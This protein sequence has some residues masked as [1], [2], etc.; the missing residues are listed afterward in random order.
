M[1]LEQLERK[2]HQSVRRDDL[3][4]DY[5][6]YINEALDEVQRRWDWADTEQATELTLLSGESEVRLPDDF[7][8]LLSRHTS[9]IM[10][11][12]T[13]TTSGVNYFPADI[14]SEAE[15]RRLNSKNSGFSSGSNMPIWIS[16]EDGVS[17]IKIDATAGEDINFRVRYY[18]KLPPLENPKAENA[19]TRAYPRMI[20]AYARALAFETVNDPAQQIHE[21]KF[22]M[23]YKRNKGSDTDKRYR[24]R[25]LRM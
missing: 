24:G 23:E 3:Q 18:A 9:P 2:V 22:E 14:R 15:I 6:E 17:F 4:G 16:N 21:T 8:N 19:L 11:R 5:P 7:K 25:S 1:N 12:N 10:V 13:D 20:Y